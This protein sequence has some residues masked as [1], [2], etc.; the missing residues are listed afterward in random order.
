MTRLGRGQSDPISFTCTC[1]A[2]SIGGTVLL[3]YRYWSNNP[4]LPLYEAEKAQDVESLATWHKDMTEKYN[5]TGKIRIARE[6]YNVTVAGTKPE[7]EEYIHHCCKHWSFAGLHLDTEEG[8]RLFFK[9]SEGCACIF[10]PENK[11]SVRVTAEITPMGVEG[12]SPSTWEDVEALLPVEFH[13]RCHEEEILLLDV[14]NV[15]ESKIGYFIDPHTGKPAVRPPIRRFSQWPQYIEHHLQDVR[16]EEKQ[17]MTYCTGGIRCEKA[18]RWM[19]A[20]IGSQKGQKVCTLQGGIAAYLSW[21]EEEIKAGRK[22]SGDSLFK[23]R[24]Y[25]F[26]ARGSIGLGV[27]MSV[28]PVS[29][30]HVCAAPSDNLS[31]CRSKGCHLILVICTSCDE[32]NPRCC[33]SCYEADIDEPI[34]RDQRPMCACESEREAKLWGGQRVKASKTQGWR[35]ARRKGP[36][37]EEH[38]NIQIKTIN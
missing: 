3:F 17:I 2:S 18:T 21:F 34:T 7:I 24:N 29:S 11:A 1:L 30:C 20:K 8:K 5:L 38:M 16:Q 27:D 6:G 32:G 19:Q 36:L 35:K 9:P 14:R 22:Q 15:Y 25:V 33:Q 12:Y 37:F 4:Q 23:G 28:E 13:R 26:D 10:G 31:K